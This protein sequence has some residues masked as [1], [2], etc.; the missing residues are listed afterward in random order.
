[1]VSR[2]EDNMLVSELIRICEE[3]K[4]KHGDIEIVYYDCEY[5]KTPIWGVDFFAEIERGPS[6][7][8]PEHLVLT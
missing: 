4:D 8:D 6:I 5:G 2:R 7:Y 1:M 3:M